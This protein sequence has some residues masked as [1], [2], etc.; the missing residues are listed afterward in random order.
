MGLAVVDGER[1]RRVRGKRKDDNQG[2]NPERRSTLWKITNIALF[3]KQAEVNGVYYQLYQRHR[4][5]TADR[6]GWSKSHQDNDARRYMA[7]K[8][9]SHL[10]A[11]WKSFA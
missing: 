1:Q 3:R 10:L 2:Y 8:L 6:E 4:A 5:A 9:L 11:E 7:K